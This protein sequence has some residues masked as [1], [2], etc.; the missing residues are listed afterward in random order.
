MVAVSDGDSLWGLQEH[1]LAVI[2]D[3]ER[4]ANYQRGGGKGTR[5]KPLPRPG[6]G[7][8]KDRLGGGSYT[9]DE[10]RAFLDGTDGRRWV[11]KQTRTVTT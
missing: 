10:V 4:A 5:P 8:K 3:T 7:P 6:V 1:L 11:D 9:E 2:A